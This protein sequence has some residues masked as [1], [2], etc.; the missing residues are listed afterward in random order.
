MKGHKQHDVIGS[1]QTKM[2][3]HLIQIPNQLVGIMFGNLSD[4][5]DKKNIHYAIQQYTS[6]LFLIHI[7]I[8]LPMLTPNHQRTENADN[9]VSVI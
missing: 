7:R 8:P 6:K 4:I 1:H 9:N 3:D 2:E 5:A